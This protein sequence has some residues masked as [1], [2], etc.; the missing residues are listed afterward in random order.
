[1]GLFDKVKQALGI[2]GVKVEISVPDE[3][4]KDNAKVDGVLCFSTKT[5]QDVQSVRVEFM[6][7]YDIGAGAQKRV[8]RTKRGS[9]ELPGFNIKANESKDVSFSLPF[10]ITMSVAEASAKDL[11][12]KGGM[13]GALGKLGAMAENSKQ[14][15]R[16]FEVSAR[17]DV[18]GSLGA[19]ATKEIKLI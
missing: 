6:E 2:G 10:S 4:K 11:E 1:M 18:K 8:T 7:R 9:V 17:V 16:R 12:A 13:L 19:G 3:V 15:N 14:G 5:D